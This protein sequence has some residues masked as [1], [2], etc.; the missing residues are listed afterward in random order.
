M[1]NPK[2]K[3]AIILYTLSK[4]HLGFTTVLYYGLVAIMLSTMQT[5]KKVIK[6]WS[7]P[8]QKEDEPWSSKKIVANLKIA[9]I[10]S[11]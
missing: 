2:N 9:R 6:K 8:L 4:L 5:F 10:I 7:T 1:V 3:H 11:C